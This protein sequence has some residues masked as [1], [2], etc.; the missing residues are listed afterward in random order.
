MTSV[1]IDVYYESSV[2]RVGAE[3]AD[4]V[5]GGVWILYA[6]PIPDALEE[7]SIVHAPTGELTREM[8]A[9]DRLWLGEDSVELTAV[10]ERANENL[11]T[12]GHVVIYL[13]QEDTQLL[14]GAVHAKGSLP[15]PVAGTSLRLTA[16]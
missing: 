2:L 13:D 14:P 6:D 15:A 10:G 4:M 5:E 11:R 16:P 12:I 8:R 7:V 9:G 1:G 3:A